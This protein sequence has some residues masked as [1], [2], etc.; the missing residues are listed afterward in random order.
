MDFGLS[1][2]Q[3]LLDETIRRYLAERVPIMRV[4]ELRDRQVG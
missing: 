4:R 2:D 1:E 3:Q